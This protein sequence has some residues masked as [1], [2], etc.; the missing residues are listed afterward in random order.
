MDLLIATSNAGKVEEL[1]DLLNGMPLRLLRLDDVGLTGLDVIE[2]ADTL[3]ANAVLKAR[4]YAQASGLAALSDD[5]GLFVDALGGAPG[6]FRARLGG[7]GLL[8]A[9]RRALLLEA[10]AG[11]PP[12]ERTAR[13]AC[14]IAIADPRTGQVET[15]RGE[16]EGRIALTESSGS[17]GFGYDPVFIP[18]GFSVTFSDLP[19]ADKNRISHRGRAAQAALPLLARLAG[20]KD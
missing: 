10:L 16:C 15:V 20:V 11:V 12:L 4:T 8:W 18:D 1:R 19:A 17:T 5:T 9:D 6:N 14:V 7:P 3:E 2:D 13:F